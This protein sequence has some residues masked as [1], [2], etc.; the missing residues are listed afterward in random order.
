MSFQGA[1]H[2]LRVDSLNTFTY[3]LWCHFLYHKRIEKIFNN[4]FKQIVLQ[5]AHHFAG[6]IEGNGHTVDD[7]D[8]SH[9]VTLR[10]YEVRMKLT[11]GSEHVICK[12]SVLAERANLLP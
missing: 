10:I 9:A 7:L 8:T 1:M 4:S 6:S 3:K 12:R 11:V 2:D 5:H